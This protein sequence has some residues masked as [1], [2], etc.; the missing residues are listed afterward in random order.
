MFAI[1]RRNA[2]VVKSYGTSYTRLFDLVV[3]FEYGYEPASHAKRKSGPDLRTFSTP[4]GHQT[5]ATTCLRQESRAVPAP[6]CFAWWDLLP[7]KRQPRRAL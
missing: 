5:R 6:L 2:D 1:P 3:T 7:S 4:S